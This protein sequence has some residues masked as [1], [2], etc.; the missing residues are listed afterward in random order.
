VF[1]AAKDASKIFELFSITK[2]QQLGE[3]ES[4]V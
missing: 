1:F 2:N 4:G 3:L